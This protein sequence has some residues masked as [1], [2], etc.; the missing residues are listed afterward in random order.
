MKISKLRKRKCT[1]S[2]CCSKLVRD[3]VRGRAENMLEDMLQN[4]V[5]QYWT[6]T[7]ENHD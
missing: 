2:S 4:K 6:L 5:T 7:G 3:A 1:F